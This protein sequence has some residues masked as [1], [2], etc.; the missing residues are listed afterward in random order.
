MYPE[1]ILPIA[2]HIPHAGTTLPGNV[3]DQFTVSNEALLYEL[4]CVTDWYTDRLFGL[5]GIAV[6]RTPVSRVV[7]DT[8]RY[9]NDAEEEKAAIGQGVI[10]TH[11]SLGNRIRRD[12]FAKERR[13]LLPV[14]GQDL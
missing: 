9:V 10:Y 11:D 2:A 3:R 1:T 7:V 4:A 8:E 5:P 13:M 6:T 14:P 12:I